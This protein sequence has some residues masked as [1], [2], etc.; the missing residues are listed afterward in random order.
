VRANLEIVPFESC[1]P[2]GFDTTL[3]GAVCVDR[4]PVPRTSTRVA[5]T[6]RRE[7]PGQTGCARRVEGI[8]RVVPSARRLAPCRECLCT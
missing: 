3:E 1:G 7:I 5:V 2:A 8:G 4:R 6:P